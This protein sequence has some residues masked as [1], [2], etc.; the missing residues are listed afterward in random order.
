MNYPKLEYV[1]LKVVILELRMNGFP[2]EVREYKKFYKVIS[3]FCSVDFE[4]NGR[5][6]SLFDSNRQI[7]KVRKDLITSVQ[8]EIDSR[9]TVLLNQFRAY[10][11][12]AHLM[13]ANTQ[14]ARHYDEQSH[15]CLALF[16]EEQENN[17]N[18][19]ILPKVG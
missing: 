4:K 1:D 9:S 6:I 12:L 8:P 17:T 10:V 11:A 15:K 5:I 19:F 7:V 2:E 14:G 3:D 18:T 13:N 16:L